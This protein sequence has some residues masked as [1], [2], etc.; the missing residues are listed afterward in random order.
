MRKRGFTLVELLVVIAIIGI[1]IGLLL[2]AVQAAREAARRMQC[3]NNLKQLGLAIQNY[4]DVNNCL[5]GFGMGGTIPYD[6]TPYVG[7]LPFF[8]Q[9]SRYQV[10]AAGDA[11]GVWQI[12]PFDASSEAFLGVIPTILCPSDGMS[13]QGTPSGGSKPFAAC[14]Y[15][16]SHADAVNGRGWWNDCRSNNAN[17]PHNSRSAFTMVHSGRGVGHGWCPNLSAVVDGLSNTVFMSERCASPSGRWDNGPDMKVKSGFVVGVGMWSGSPKATCMTQVGNNGN[18]IATANGRN[19]S[20]SLFGMWYNFHAIVHLIMPPN[21]PSCGDSDQ[22]TLVMTPTSYHSGGVNCVLGDGS[23]RFV[24][25]T[26][27]CGDLSVP[28]SLNPAGKTNDH[29]VTGPSPYGV[30]GAMGTING[31][32]SLSNI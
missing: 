16:F 17:C 24:S 7:M 9:N 1:L 22:D 4:H 28:V 32:E 19:G 26:V 15:R 25:D 11:N 6:Y 29:P 8:E 14:N 3:T 31:G 18:Y 20:G 23:V 2:P 5:P 27:D 30:W 10:I 21:G 12:E 13:S